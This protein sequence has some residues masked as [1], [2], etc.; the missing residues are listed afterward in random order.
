MSF[1]SATGL[2]HADAQ[3]ATVLTMTNDNILSNG[4]FVYGPNI[5]NFIIKTYLEKYA[6][7]LL[8][9]ADDLY[10]RSEYYSIN[11][12]V[13]LTLLEIHSH[14]ISNPNTALLKDSFGLSNGDF[15]SQV[16]VLSDKM[17][18]AYYL[19][20]YSYSPLP[21]SERYLPSFVTPDGVTINVAPDTNAGTYAIIAGLSAM[22]E[23]NI[24]LL[25][26]NSQINGFY[27]TY[28]R[29]FGNNNPLDEKNKIT[30][31][32]VKA[33]ILAA[34]NN[35]LQLPY[36][37]GLSW[38]FGGV[39]NTSGG[40]TFTD[41]S[42]LDFYPWPISWGA[43]TSN[44]WVVAAASGIPTRFSDCGYKIS[45]SGAVN[46][47]WE[48][49]YYHLEGAKYLSGP[50]NQNEKIGVI[51]NTEAEATCTGG[52]A[53]GP[54]VHFSLK[55]NGVYVA[56]NGTSLSGWYVHSG[57]YSYDVDPAY[58]W[59]ERAGRKKYAYTD[60]VLSD[61]Y[62]P[63][64]FDDVPFD[65]FARAQIETIYNDGITG[66]CSALPLSYCPETTVTRAQMAVFL[67]RG[68][69]GSSYNPPIVGGDTGFE[70]VLPDYWAAAWIKQLAVD[71]ITGGCGSGKYCPE[72]PVTRAQMAVFLLRSKYG[73]S[74]SPPT[75]GG[76]T[77]FTDV[78]TTYWA[79][80][81]IKQ[82][83]AE[84]IT[85]GCGSDTYCPDAPVTRAQMAVFLVRTFNLP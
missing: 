35:L 48:T 32:T 18:E 19:H 26:D 79:A 83:V 13:Y 63:G 25:V 68:I 15:I 47:G 62:I 70:D 20:L 65:G 5:G 85:A 16:E 12:Q 45:H 81:W 30:A 64:I 69:H 78:D 77:G 84:G 2:S 31:L 9:Y 23:Q 51:A 29:L 46:I 72:A 58:M 38:R 53:S 27:Q 4:Q 10:G 24:S 76:S 49:V 66:G 55:Y 3:E 59:L 61:N 7:H 42:S 34:P 43:D 22:N 40:T 6:P 11:P 33:G 73:S 52:A 57:R 36:L 75:V 17:S 44:M 8:K 54:H 71:G 39:H 50:V 82:L 60:G 14:L 37:Q 67:E 21:V 74:Y 80:A 41:A 56:I 28:R 1:F